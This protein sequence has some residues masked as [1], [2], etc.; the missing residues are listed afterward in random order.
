MG[1]WSMP[2]A[3]GIVAE[4]RKGVCMQHSVQHR[5]PCLCVCVGGLLTTQ[6]S[7]YQG[8]GLGAILAKAC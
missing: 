5:G 3:N 6:T 8:L 2:V 4:G 7:G 1:H